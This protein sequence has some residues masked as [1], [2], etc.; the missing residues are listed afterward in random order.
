MQLA[1]MKDIIQETSTKREI[2]MAC[3]IKEKVLSD[4]LKESVFFKKNQSFFKNPPNTS[5]LCE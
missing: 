5:T 2:H 4:S 3:L 1:K